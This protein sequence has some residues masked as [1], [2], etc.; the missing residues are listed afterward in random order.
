MRLG[1]LKY[2]H[3]TFKASES[4]GAGW[5]GA[6]GLV[7]A[8][9][10]L[11]RGSAHSGLFAFCLPWAVSGEGNDLPRVPQPRLQTCGPHTEP[12][13][14]GAWVRIPRLSV[15]VHSAKIIISFM[16]R[17]DPKAAPGRG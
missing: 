7:P 8:L 16:K 2:S 3:S 1:S 14:S 17:E 4:R 10:G 11:R 13:V 9:E 15:P 5:T 6:P 12:D